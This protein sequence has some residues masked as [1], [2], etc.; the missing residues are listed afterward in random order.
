VKAPRRALRAVEEI[1]TGREALALAAKLDAETRAA[2]ASGRALGRQRADAADLLYTGGHAAEGLRLATAA[3]DA[4]LAAA[5]RYAGATGAAAEGDVPKAA[6]EALGVAPRRVAELEKTGAEVWAAALPRLEDDVA[7]AHAA[8]YERVAQAQRTVDRALGPAGLERRQIVASRA[9]RVSL[10]AAVLIG[11]PVAY[12]AANRVPE[13]VHAHAS[14]T[15]ANAPS[16]GPETVIDGREDT[17][18]LL[19]DRSEGWVEVTMSPARHI[20]RIGVLNCWN[21]P[22]GDRA[23][24]DYRLEI[25]DGDRLVRS[26]DGTFEH[27][28]SPSRVYHAVGIDDVSRVRFVVRSHHRTGG[29]L[30]EITFE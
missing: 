6:L 29:G 22:H 2:I 23:T 17:W 14:G 7:P 10:L 13:G 15:W 1:V 26:I 16:F 19:P 20:A 3:L 21:P 24:R 5:T 4:T 25:Y 18:W 28:T 8:L 11:L 9:A 12:W 30:A 27:S